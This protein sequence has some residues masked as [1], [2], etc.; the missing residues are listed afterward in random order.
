MSWNSTEISQVCWILQLDGSW[1]SS[2][3]FY[4]G[5]GRDDVG[6]PEGF[7]IPVLVTLRALPLNES[8]VP[9]RLIVGVPGM[10]VPLDPEAVR[11]LF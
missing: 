11:P 8:E 3:H 1:Q 2:F 7:R 10:P 6:V 5:L 4:L 9:S